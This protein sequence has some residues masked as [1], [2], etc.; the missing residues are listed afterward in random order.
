MLA[1]RDNLEFWKQISPKLW[2]LSKSFVK[3]VFITKCDKKTS[4]TLF[5]PF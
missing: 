4:H 1:E 3:T 2:I 5:E